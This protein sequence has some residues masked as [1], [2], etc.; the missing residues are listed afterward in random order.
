MGL[1]ASPAASTA[2][3]AEENLR[4]RPDNPRPAEA[5]ERA[6]E[7]ADAAQTVVASQCHLQDRTSR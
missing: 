2:I 3:L 6:I 7:A 4:G 1:L 5:S